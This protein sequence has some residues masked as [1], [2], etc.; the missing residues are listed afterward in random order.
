MKYMLPAFALVVALGLV[1]AQEPGESKSTTERL[2]RETPWENPS[3]I[4]NFHY[5]GKKREG[6]FL[7][8]LAPDEGRGRTL[9]ITQI[10]VRMRQST[11]W[12]VVEHRPARKQGKEAW[13]KVIRR[14][15]LF[16]LGWQESTSQ[17]LGVGLG[18]LPG[19]K[20]D[21]GTRPAIEF[22]EG[23]GDVAV[24]AEGIWSAP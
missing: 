8:L 5:E 12:Q 14:S 23:S 4:W 15:E 24:Y 9:V 10:S 22:T 13:E 16:S 3:L 7:E 21:P 6:D 2:R 1:L 17:Y 11:R 20:C 18:G 19:M